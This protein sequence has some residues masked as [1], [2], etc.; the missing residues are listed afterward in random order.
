[1]SLDNVEQQVIQAFQHVLMAQLQSNIDRV[2]PLMGDTVSTIHKDKIQNILLRSSR[3]AIA[4]SFEVLSNEEIIHWSKL[5]QQLSSPEFKAIDNKLRPI[6]ASSIN[7][8]VDQ[9]MNVITG[10]Q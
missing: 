8:T 3:A 7:N 10:Q 2:L 5:Y 4:R 1:M 9:I 6:M